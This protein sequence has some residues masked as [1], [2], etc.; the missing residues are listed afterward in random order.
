MQKLPFALLGS[1][2]AAPLALP[3]QT[4]KPAE[5]P[6]KYTGG[7]TGGPITA[8][9]LK[10][11]LYIFA[12][13][14]MEGREAGSR[15]HFR[16]TTY[17]AA[18]L[19]RMGLEP[20]GDQ[21]TYFQTIP[22]KALAPMVHL[23]V[24]GS[25]LE[26][27]RDA[28]PLP[29]AYGVPFG[30]SLPEGEH[31][32]VF[33]GRLGAG[34]AIAPDKVAGKVV[35]FLA[36]IAPNGRPAFGFW[37]HP[38]FPTYEGAAG[39]IIVALDLL[40]PQGRELLSSPS[41]VYLPHLTSVPFAMVVTPAAAERLVGG[42]LDTAKAGTAGLPLTGSA[43]FEARDGE[44][45]ARNVVAVLRGSDPAFRNQY[46]AIG[47]HSDHV[48]IQD[49]KVDHDSLRAFNSIVRPRGA[50]DGDKPATASDLPLIR[51]MLDSLRALRAGRPD[52]IA[53]GAD[54]DGTGSVAVL[55][56]AQAMADAPQKP[57]RSLLFI[58]HVAEELGLFGSEHFTDHPTVPRD[59]IVAE[60]NIDMI[61]RGNASDLPGGGPG[62]VQLI[63]SRRL[64]TE[65]GDLVERRNTEGRHGLRFDY[66]FDVD[67][68]PDQY[69]CRSD[70]Y[71]Y[72][73]YGIPVVFLSTGG[74]RDY[75]QVT[76]EPQ[77]IDYDHMA[78]VTGFI[79]D[80]AETVA[81]LGHRVVVDKPKPDPKAECH[82]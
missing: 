16:A 77:Y 47:A 18:E 25:A 74:H 4:T 31:S 54:D 49:H 60:I 45:P 51:L 12:D 62:Y 69:Y 41:T 3:A 63:G 65:L 28:L 1:L 23:V 46:V 53:N 52:S 40:G 10:T 67:G 33:G 7:P 68:H 9:D 75:H 20:A 35:I 78:K 80:L 2:L 36:P 73:R 6:L 66:Q 58:W 42:P 26:L 59:S 13:D 27:G 50:D 43:G 5:G 32:T 38:A 24:G 34:D 11:R 21:G 17:L 57:K 56:I 8:A 19:A 72:A 30:G 44:A 15:G 76:D 29:G 37:Q 39:F 22:L 82:Q 71:N 70:H 55:E 64:S 61:G 79:K 48:G 81:N 14:S